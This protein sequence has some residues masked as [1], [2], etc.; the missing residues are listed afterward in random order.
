MGPSRSFLLWL[1]IPQAALFSRE[2]A[3]PSWSRRECSPRWDWCL[4]FCFLPQS[5][6]PLPAF[7][8]LCF[9]PSFLSFLKF[10]FPSLTLLFSSLASPSLILLFFLYSLLAFLASRLS[11]FLFSLLFSSLFTH[12]TLSSLLPFSCLSPRFVPDRRFDE[13]RQ[14]NQESSPNST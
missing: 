13:Q 8:P 12:H 9:L 2:R 3:K 6:C 1:T 5:L 14:R 7:L 11:L 10:G 4:S